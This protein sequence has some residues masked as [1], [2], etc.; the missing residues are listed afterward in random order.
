MVLHI[1]FFKTL[2]KSCD[3]LVHRDRTI[4]AAD[5]QG[6]ITPRIGS[7][8]SSVFMEAL[9]NTT[10]LMLQGK[11]IVSSHP[12]QT[13]GTESDAEE[14]DGV[15][16]ATH[17]DIAA[18]PTTHILSFLQTYCEP[19][20]AHVKNNAYCTCTFREIK[21]SKPRLYTSAFTCL[22]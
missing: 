16:T 2:N 12:S 8:N 21:S 20:V 9:K 11:W 14:C 3:T 1:S 13:G 22:A 7:I 15:V 18:M 6:L 19:W 10:S 4:S 5:L 17:N